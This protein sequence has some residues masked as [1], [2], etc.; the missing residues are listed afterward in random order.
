MTHNNIYV[1]FMIEYDKANVTS[2]YPSLTEYEVATVLDKAYN[3][4][5]AQKITG[6]NVRRAP[7]EADVKAISDLQPLIVSE[8]KTL[9]F[10]SD[11]AVKN[12]YYA[13]L[14]SDFLYYVGCYLQTLTKFHGADV[15]RD[16]FVDNADLSAFNTSQANDD[17]KGDVDNDGEVAINDKSIIYSVQSSRR[18]NAIV[19]LPCQ[20]VDF[21]TAQKFFC[22]AY[23]LP[24]V[25]NPVCYIQGDYIYVL[26]DSWKE[27][28]LRN[29]I[30]VHYIKKPQTFVKDLSKYSDKEISF[31]S[32]KPGDTTFE[33]ND[34]MAEELINLAIIYAL[35]NVESPRLNT[36]LNT[37][38][39][40]G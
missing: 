15:N 19:S 23:N 11:D 12:R 32:G 29:K 14:P 25:K 7:F 37:R 8:E 39:L 24:W 36:K 26:T 27:D 1:K 10:T 18:P 21:N 5:I 13:K 2:S 30:T 16:G 40:E 28:Q 35:E 3:A 33:L 20:I 34:T 38:G 4:L 22:T 17:L 31:F 6:N 9:Q